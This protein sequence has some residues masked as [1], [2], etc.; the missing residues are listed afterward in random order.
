ML[1]NNNI[2]RQLLFLAFA[3]FFQVISFGQAKLLK[4]V[5]EK[6]DIGK[7]YSFD[8]STKK[9]GFDKIFIK[10]LGRIKTDKGKEI[11]ILSWSRI[12]GKNRHTSGAIYIYDNVNTYIGKYTLGSSLDL[13]GKIENK[14]LIFKNKN[15]NDCDSTLVTKINFGRGIPKDIFIKCKGSSGD[16]YSFSIDE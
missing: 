15:K 1:S 11:N 2:C 12:W 9:D 10:Y 8:S 7:V 13:P 14:N 6:N 5:L 4:S 16:I 3:F